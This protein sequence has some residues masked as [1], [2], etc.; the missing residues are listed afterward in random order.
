M[1]LSEGCAL[2]GDHH[3]GTQITMYDHSKIQEGLKQ[4]EWRNGRD[5]V[6]NDPVSLYISN[7][8]LIYNQIQ[9]DN[10]LKVNEI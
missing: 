3:N 1:V 6:N 4:E 8:L 7:H 5:D 10:N 2:H 9:V